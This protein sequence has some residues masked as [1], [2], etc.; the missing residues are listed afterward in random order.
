[1]RLALIRQRYT[2]GGGAERFLEAALEALLER[3]VAI[4][5]YTREWPE[6]KLQLIEPHICDPSYYGRLWRDWGFAREVGRAIGSTRANLVQSYERVLC[7]DIYRPTDGVHA[8]WLEERLSD[9]PASLRLRVAVDPWHRYTLAMERRLFASPWLR[10][11]LCDSHMV[12]DDIK[13][14]F[15][16]PDERLPVIYNAVDSAAF[17][18]ALAEFRGRTRAQHQIPE[19]ATVFLLVG[20]G[21]R[22]KGV[23]AALSA[24]AQLPPST[25]LL[26][27]G[28]DRRNGDFRRQARALGVRDRVTFVGYQP[29]VAPYYGAADAFVLPAIYDAFP[30]AALEALASG[31]PVITS[32]RS[33]AAELVTASDAGFV[34]P[35]RDVD[36]LAAHMRCLL[37][38]SLRAAMSARAREA[39]LPLSPEAMTLKLV[40]L[41]KQLLEASVA[42]RMP[43]RAGAPA[44]GVT[45]GVEA[46]PLHGDDGLEP[47]T[48]PADAR[49]REPPPD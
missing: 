32:T 3:N 20:S 34:C 46:A 7:C 31:L 2:P 42:H 39:A 38:P 48:L 36:Q 47:E 4:T 12:R 25:H 26:V 35:S 22:K 19:D 41:Y 8:T 24:L 40:L 14:R 21:F 43:G 18:P 29:Q 15:G 49:R 28:E 13:A 30:S 44:A 33:G 23:P 9:A 1:M 37:D 27:V 5:L 45:A 10:A 16:L 11:V 6:T 17:S